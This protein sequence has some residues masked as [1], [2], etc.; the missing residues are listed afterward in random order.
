MLPV[1]KIIT[2]TDFSQ[3]ALNGVHA[4]VELAQ[5]FDAELFLV[6][7]TQPLQTVSGAS[8]MAG[9]H[10]PTVE[11]EIREEVLQLADQLVKAEIPDSLRSQEDDGPPS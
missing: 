7:V 2:T 4:A 1:K 11:K 3:P 10:L 8:T 9:H 5:T 6:H